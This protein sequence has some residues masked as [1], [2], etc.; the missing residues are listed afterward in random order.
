M[1]RALRRE[2]N[3][4]LGEE[5]CGEETRG[6]EDGAEKIRSEGRAVEGQTT[7]VACGEPAGAQAWAGDTQGLIL[8]MQNEIKE[9][10]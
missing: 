9:R 7:R 10:S 4:G 3:R 8:A 6:R 2:G 1:D 5:R